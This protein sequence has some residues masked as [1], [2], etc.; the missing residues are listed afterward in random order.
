MDNPS[1]KSN[2]EELPRN[3][4]I[5]LLPTPPHNLA[6]GRV[7]L[8]FVRI[9]PGDESRGLVP[10]YHFRIVNGEGADV[11]HINFR[12]G[13]TDHVR[14]CAGHIGFE[15]LQDFRGR[16]Y[17]LEAC[18]ALAPFVRSIYSVVTITANPDN[19]ASIHTIEKLGATFFDEAPVPPHDPAFSAGARRK[20]RYQWSLENL[21]Q[22]HHWPPLSFS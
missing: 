16:G 17:A 18:R 10:A 12:V 1:P 3:P 2:Q 19:S 13:D 6:F 11:G 5:E 9:V 15:V 7:R 4:R 20:R 21:P 14:V 8:R 22:N